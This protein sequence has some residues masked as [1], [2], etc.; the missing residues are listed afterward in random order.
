VELA[1]NLIGHDFFT[2][3]L[4]DPWNWY[5]WFDAVVPPLPEEAALMQW[6]GGRNR[7]LLCRSAA[8]TLGVRSLLCLELW[9]PPLARGRRHVRAVQGPLPHASN[10]DPAP[11]LRTAARLPAGRGG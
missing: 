3:F 1:I 11:A 2:Q 8:A 4:P 10:S 5:A 9:L 7:S 6:E